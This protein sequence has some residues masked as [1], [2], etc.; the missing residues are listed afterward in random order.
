MIPIVCQDRIFGVDIVINRI[1]KVSRQG[2]KLRIDCRF[3]I[4]NTPRIDLIVVDTITAIAV[5]LE[6]SSSSSIQ[7]K[8]EDLAFENKWTQ[9]HWRG[10]F[11]FLFQPCF[12]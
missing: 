5:D 12:S 7:Q 3:C 9:Q 11:I 2:I 4:Y 1:I 6:K 8:P 10:P